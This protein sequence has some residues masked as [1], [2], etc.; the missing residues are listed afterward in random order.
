[1]C[2]CAVDR[3]KSIDQLESLC[4][5]IVHWRGHMKMASFGGMLG[6][7]LTLSA[8]G[9]FVFVC[10][11]VCFVRVLGLIWA[12]STLLSSVGPAFVIPVHRLGR[13]WQRRQHQ[14]GNWATLL[15]AGLF[16]F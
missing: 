14:F 10:A 9:V 1:M 5:G 3:S 11:I 4:A 13:G 8:D 7:G 12:L 6:F 2:L 15:F 16:V